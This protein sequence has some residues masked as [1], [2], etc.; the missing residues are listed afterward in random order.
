MGEVVGE[1]NRGVI[2]EKRGLEG[3]TVGRMDGG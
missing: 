2:G 1:N 3:E